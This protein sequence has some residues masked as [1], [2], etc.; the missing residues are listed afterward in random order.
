MYMFYSQSNTYLYF[1]L[2][3]YGVMLRNDIRYMVLYLRLF[4]SVKRLCFSS[5]KRIYLHM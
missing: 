4:S 1:V 3:R 2:Y 5:V